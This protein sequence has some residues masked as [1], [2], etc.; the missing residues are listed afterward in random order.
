[1]KKEIKRG[2]AGRVFYLGAFFND[3]ARADTESEA[4]GRVGGVEIHGAGGG[5]GSGGVETLGR[6]GEVRRGCGRSGATGAAGVE[7]AGEID[8]VFFEEVAAVVCMRGASEPEGSCV[9]AGRIRFSGGVR[10]SGGCVV[11]RSGAGGDEGDDEHD[12][13]VTVGAGA[14]L[15]AVQRSVAPVDGRP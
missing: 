14:S 12:G 9:P 6:F 7:S 8:D 10:D 15:R 4:A 11:H 2:L 1:V 5:A 13:V 3:G